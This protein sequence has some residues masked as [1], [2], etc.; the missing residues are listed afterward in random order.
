MVD[1]IIIGVTGTLGAGKGAVVEYLKSKYGFTH[2]SVRD[3][4]TK[5]IEKRG[6]P[7]NRDSMVLAGNDLRAKN[8]PG[9]IVE[10]LYKQAV[11]AGGNAVIESIRTLGELEVL[12][13]QSNFYFIAVDAPAEIRF[14]RIQHRAAATDNVTFEKFLADEARE[15][16]SVDPN[17]QNLK[18]C[19]ELADFVFINDK[20]FVELDRQIDKVMAKI[21]S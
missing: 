10:E 21:Q 15:M 2:Y 11:E 5:E 12:K 3:F 9:F 18:G 20:T 17:K 14:K 13:R 16:T 19:I 4:L 7:L 6:L 1:M 8:H